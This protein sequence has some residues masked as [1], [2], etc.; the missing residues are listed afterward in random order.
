MK[1]ID[2]H[3][4]TISSIYLDRMG[5]E[6]KKLRENNGHGIGQAEKGRLPCAEFR[7]F[8]LY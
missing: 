8:Y 6:V 5:G 1:F 7:P 2:M 3:C 4:D